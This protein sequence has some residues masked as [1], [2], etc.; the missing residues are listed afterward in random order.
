MPITTKDEVKTL[1]QIASADTSKDTLI[2]SLIVKVQDFIVRRINNF[3]VPEI[4][5][6]GDNIS[7]A[8]TSKKIIDADAE[9]DHDGFAVGNDILVLGS[10]Q[11]DKIFSIKTVAAGEI[12]VNETVV[13]EAAGSLIFIRRVQFTEDIKMAAADFIAFKLNKEKTVKS[14]SLGDH[15]ESF[16]NQQEMLET[17]STFRKLQW[18]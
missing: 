18:D 5:V 12:E 8:A 15:S 17:F 9:L 1:L 13:E 14:R 7:F 3:I 11:N 2:D 6:Q 4:Y 10:Y 16:F